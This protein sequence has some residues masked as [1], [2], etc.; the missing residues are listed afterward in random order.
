MTHTHL[1]QAVF[2]EP[3]LITPA[4]HA[5]IREIVKA[6]V[7]TPRATKREGT[8]V[9]GEAVE[10]ESMTVE[11]GVA[12]IP[13]AGVL[14]R[15]LSSFEKGAGAVDFADIEKDL[16]EAEDD[17]RV[18]SIVLVFD[19]PGGMCNGTPEL[20]E[21][22]EASTKDV[23][24]WVPGGCYSAAYWLACSC[25]GIFCATSAGVGN[26]GVYIPW[27]DESQAFENAGIVA[28]PITSG[29]YKAMGFPGTSL[30]AEQRQQLQDMVNSRAEDFKEQV[31][32]NRGDIGDELMLGQAFDAKDA[33]ALGLIDGIYRSLDDMIQSVIGGEVVDRL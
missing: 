8:D 3:W 23:W 12:R 11:N 2:G 1:I 17:P 15:K 19:S 27:Y 16:D 28:D 22:I 30:S 26:I 29:P 9:C 4:A 7:L 24:A 10:L 14:G 5:S 33:L 21:R 13:V 32:R 18:R 31:R 25:E 20:A 6:H